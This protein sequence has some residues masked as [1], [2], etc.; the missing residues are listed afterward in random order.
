[1]LQTSNDGG[2]SEAKKVKQGVTG[3]YRCY[4]A[5]KGAVSV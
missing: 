1:M 5:K 4:K 2:S 3:A